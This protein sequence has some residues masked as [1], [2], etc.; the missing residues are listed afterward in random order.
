VWEKYRQEIIKNNKFNENWF[1]LGIDLGTTH[2][3]VSYFNCNSKRPEPI[4]ISQG[5]GKI[6][7]PSVVQFRNEIGPEWIVG[8]EAYK[9]MIMYPQD[10]VTSVKRKM[11]TSEEIL[12]GDQRYLPEEISGIILQELLQHT[13]SLNPNRIIAGVVVSVPYDF[14][15]SAKKATVKAC[16][17]AGL[18]ESL[19]CLIEEPKAAALTYHF[20]NALNE[21]K[22]MMIFDFGGGTLDI[23]VFHVSQMT[24]DHIHLQVI[25]EGGDAYHGGDQID[26]MILDKLYTMIYDEV[27][28]TKDQLSNENK[29]ELMQ[30]ARD[31]K[32]RLSGVK[33]LR[34]PFTFCIPPFMKEITRIQ[35][36]TI[37]DPFIQATR[38]LVLKTLS[39]GYMGAIHPADI[40]FVL[41]EG[42]SSSM[43]WVKDM[44]ISIFNDY[45]KIYSSDKPALNISIGATYYAAIKMGLLEHPDMMATGQMVHFEITVPHDIGFEIDYGTKKEFHTMISRGTPYLLAKKT[46]VF[47]LTGNTQEEM[48]N[49]TIRILE[50][51]RKEDKIEKCRLIGEVFVE[52]LPERPSGKTKLKVTLSVE[53]ESGIVRGEVEDLGYPEMFEPSAFKASFSPNRVVRTIL[54]AK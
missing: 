49:L 10:T 32:E 9:S 39:D 46:Q 53:E 22:K 48:T 8:D 14:D 52:G 36:E 11:G 1:I 4:D 47:T 2:S 5:F 18:G 28:L 29:V 40:D 25:S 43:P 50:R 17:L 42:G 19:I 35:I 12:L 30:S 38:Q 34:V 44:L 26:A 7:M 51:M 45:E 13:L 41:L 23:T 27:G 21:G 37:I 31:I 20:K 6:P 16:Q 54:N 33:K 3:V 24:S 15:D